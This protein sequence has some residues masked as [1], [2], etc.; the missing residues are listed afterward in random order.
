MG[1]CGVAKNKTIVI[2]VTEDEKASIKR[3]A[4]SM[5]MTVTEF[6]LY[7]ALKTIS[8]SELEKLV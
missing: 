4:V 6:L 8:E 1:W 3:I 7:G 2:R 5:Q